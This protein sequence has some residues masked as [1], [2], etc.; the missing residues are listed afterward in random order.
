MIEIEIYDKGPTS[1]PPSL[2]NISFFIYWPILM[3]FDFFEG[4]GGG[5]FIIYFYLNYTKK[6]STKFNKTST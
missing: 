6:K 1:P 3:K 4:G 2:K 5:P